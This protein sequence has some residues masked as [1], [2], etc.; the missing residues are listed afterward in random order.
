MYKAFVITF[1][2]LTALIA[3]TAQ[4]LPGLHNGDFDEI[5]AFSSNPSL[6]GLT[7]DSVQKIAKNARNADA[8]LQS[9]Y[10]CTALIKS[11]KGFNLV[12]APNAPGIS[13]LAA[14]RLCPCE[15]CLRISKCCGDSVT[16]DGVKVPCYRPVACEKPPCFRNMECVGLAEGQTAVTLEG[17]KESVIEGTPVTNPCYKVEPSLP[18]HTGYELKVISSGVGVTP[19]H[20][21]EGSPCIGLEPCCAVDGS[22]NCFILEDCCV[23][24]RGDQVS[25]SK[26]CLNF[27]RCTDPTTPTTP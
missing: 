9:D 1:L 3:I 14:D 6:L 4:P 26:R 5:F 16:A 27:N 18:G 20:C 10:Q 25:A 19:V 15:S 2:A 17:I 22:K 21:A 23:P 12:P 13:F 8:G 7:L 24:A 11:D